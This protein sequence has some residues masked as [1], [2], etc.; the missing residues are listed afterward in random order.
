MQSRN[1]RLGTFSNDE[2][3][4][5]RRLGVRLDGK[6][7]LC[8]DPN[9]FAIEIDGDSKQPE[10][11]HE[12]TKY[13]KWLGSTTCLNPGPNKEGPRETDDCSEAGNHHET[14][15]DGRRIGFNDLEDLQI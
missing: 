8:G 12:H 6:P 11:T 3:G 7:F 10:Y 14:V 2:T 13:P 9:S 4:F 5:C 15:I 1:S